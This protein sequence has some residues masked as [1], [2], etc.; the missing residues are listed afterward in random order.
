MKKI[1]IYIGIITGLSVMF[2]FAY[3][4]SYRQALKKL[5]KQ[6]EAEE[7]SLNGRIALLSEEKEALLNRLSELSFSLS[8]KEMQ[9]DIEKE[10]DEE[11]EVVGHQQSKSVLPSATM[12]LETYQTVTDQMNSEMKTTPGFMIGMTREELLI[13]LS[14]Y[15]QNLSISEYEAGLLSYELI[16]FSEN[17]VI[18]RKTYNENAI[19]FKYYVNITKGMVTVFYSDLKTVYEYTHI[20]AVE[21]T[22]DLRNNLLRGI[23]VKN[24]E[25]LYAL[26]ESCSS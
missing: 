5:N 3:F 16:S 14:D 12:I 9:T 22:E 8:E 13:Y 7:N 10:S 15:M 1:L 25:E 18:L 19:P 24:R 21:L 4:Q 2:S 17:R 11:T 6:T 26:L 20:P 23:Y